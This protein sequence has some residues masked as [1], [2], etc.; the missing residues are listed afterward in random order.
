VTT[1]EARLVTEA[2]ALSNTFRR[3]AE[4]MDHRELVAAAYRR[5]RRA[6]DDVRAMLGDERVCQTCMGY[7]RVVFAA[8][9]APRKSEPCPEC[10]GVR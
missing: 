5:A 1:D 2:R 4:A 7:G 8:T 10:G 9:T 3:R 6:L